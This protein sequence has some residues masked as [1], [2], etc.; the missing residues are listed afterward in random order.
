MS[1]EKELFKLVFEAG[2][3]CGNAGRSNIDALSEII[4]ADFER[5]WQNAGLSKV[6]A[7]RDE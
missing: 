3:N 2:Y 1:L 5:F 6:R 7:Y 4:D